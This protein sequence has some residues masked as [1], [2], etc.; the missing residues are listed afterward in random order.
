MYRSFKA[1]VET[2]VDEQARCSTLTMEADANTGSMGTDGSG[3]QLAVSHVP[4][5]NPDPNPKPKPK[6]KPAPK[7]KTP[8][9]LARA[10]SWR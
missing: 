4:Y 3:S 1:V 5:S 8:V 2:D 6:P 7:A 10:V 9:Q